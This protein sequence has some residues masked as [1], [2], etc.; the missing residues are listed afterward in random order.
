MQE[1]QKNFGCGVHQ[2]KVKLNAVRRGGVGQFVGLPYGKV[3]HD[4]QVRVGRDAICLLDFP[5]LLRLAYVFPGIAVRT[6]GFVDCA[7]C[8]GEACCTIFFKKIVLK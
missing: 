8:V 1:F 2:M 7:Y 3:G 5:L 6:Q 4:G